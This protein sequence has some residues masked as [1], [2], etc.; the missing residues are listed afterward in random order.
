[1]VLQRKKD[2][3]SILKTT[4]RENADFVKVLPE[5][6]WLR[7]AVLLSPHDLLKLRS[8]SKKFT[9]YVNTNLVWASF[10]WYVFLL[11][12]LLLMIVLLI[13]VGRRDFGNVEVA[14]RNWREHYARSF[15]QNK[16]PLTY[17]T[18]LL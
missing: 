3:A 4:D 9:K 10:S 14:S 6:I 8:L 18:L 2:R 1:M 17:V 13:V 12:F 11:L 5:L 16:H 7:V 15:V